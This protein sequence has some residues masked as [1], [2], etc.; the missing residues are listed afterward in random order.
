[1]ITRIE[2]E[3]F[4]GIRDRVVLELKPI[5]LLFGANSSG[6]STVFHALHYAL[7]VLGNHN[8]DADRTTLGGESVDLGG[9]RSLVHAHD[10]DKRIIMLFAFD[11][12][13][14][15]LPDHTVGSTDLLPE[16]RGLADDPDLDDLV[17]SAWVRVEI[18]WSLALRAPQVFAYEIGINGG[19]EPVIRIEAGAGK[20][21]E[22]L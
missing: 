20:G 7:E 4:K 15:T 12:T 11:A 8:L 13:D 6:K 14:S 19:D 10:L 16:S 9:F 3:N 18:G 21:Q 1:M 2:L 17:T 5:T 22:R